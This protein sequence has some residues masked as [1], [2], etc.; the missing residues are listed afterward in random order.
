MY[1][2]SE[3]IIVEDLG[4]ST[5]LFD[6]QTE[7]FYCFTDVEQLIWNLVDLQEISYIVEMICKEYDVAFEQAQ[8]DAHNFCTSLLEKGLI[9]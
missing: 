2:K 7:T 6:E 4:E 3:H 5:M 9:I 8:K 1:Q